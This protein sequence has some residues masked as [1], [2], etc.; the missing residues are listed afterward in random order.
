M[1]LGSLAF[2]DLFSEFFREELA[3]DKLLVSSI[4]SDK[5]I[6]SALLHDFAF[7]EHDNLVSVPDGRKS[8]SNHDASL[9]TFSNELVQGFLHLVLTFG[10]EC[11]R[12]LVQK[13]HL[14]LA[15]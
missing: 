8:V 12:G 3:G 13:N 6:V 4:E 7:L 15:D 14:R 11:A 9:L 10:I 5:F 2:L 1:R